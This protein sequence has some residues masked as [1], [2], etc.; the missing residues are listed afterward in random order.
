MFLTYYKK[1]GHLY[2]RIDTSIRNSGK[3]KKTYKNLGRV[4]DKEIFFVV[5]SEVILFMISKLTLITRFLQILNLL[6]KREEADI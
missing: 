4:L 6:I 1:S 3:V 5:V 2:A